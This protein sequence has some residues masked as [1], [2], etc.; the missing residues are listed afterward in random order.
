MRLLILSQ[1]YK[2]EPVP[3]PSE[4][5]E[6]LMSRGHQVSVLT[7]YPN[8]P[9]GKLY[10]GYR[11]R[12]AERAVVDGVAVVRAFEFPDHGTG[13]LRRM[14]NYLSFMIS[15]PLASVLAPRCDV[16]YVWHPPLTA[17]VAAALIA[18][19]RG[20]AFV[21]DVQD[22]WPE[23]AVLSGMLRPGLLVRLMSRLERIVYRQAAHILVTTD[24]AKENLVAKGVPEGKVSVMPHWIDERVFTPVG[25][26]TRAAVRTRERWDGR[27][28]VMFAGNLGLVQ[29]LDTVLAAAAGLPASGNTRIVIVGD[30]TDRERLEARAQALGLGDRVQF[31]GRQPAAVMPDLFAAADALL[32]HLKRSELSRL[33]IP[34][35]T[36]AYLAAGRPII[37]A[38]EGA[39]ADLVTRAGAGIAVPPDDVTRLVEGIETLRRMSDAERAEM[40]ARG[41]A[42][43]AAHFTQKVVIPQYEAL[44]E[45]MAQADRT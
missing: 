23:S 28:V 37:M 14:A 38:M 40:G 2:P 6:A 7:G 44:L 43:V 22:I 1:Y 19:A 21:Y 32:V 41:T 5:A 29:G 20:V 33:V 15:A 16:I 18:R 26:V 36:L 35:K 4:L 13:L 11:L 34:T 42:H 3:K 25:D 27:F 45:R 12:P 24:G 10:E 17:G 39:A 9:A 8:Y 30:G 31:I